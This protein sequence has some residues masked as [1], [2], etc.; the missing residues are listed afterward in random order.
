MAREEEEELSDTS[1]SSKQIQT[2]Q[3]FIPRSFCTCSI[4]I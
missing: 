1:P 4:A 3:K 2:N